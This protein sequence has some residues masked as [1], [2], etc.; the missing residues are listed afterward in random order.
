MRGAV[1]VRSRAALVWAGLALVGLSGCTSNNAASS[2]VTVSGSTLT[3]FASQPPAGSGGQTAAD[4]LHA[5]QLALQQAGGHVG[6]F[7]VKLVPLDGRELSDNARTAIQNQSAIAYLGE[8]QPGTSQ[9]S[10]QITNQQGVL[11]VSPADT[12]AYLTQPTPV[13][14]GAPSEYYPAHSTYHETFAR[15]VP[16]SGAEAKAQ[17]QEM[18]SLGVSK[19]YVAH[20]AQA[21]SAAIALEVTQEAKAA[22]LTAATSAASADGVFYA[23]SSDSPSARASATTAL[24]Q[25][26]S[27]NPT[28]KLFAPSGLYNPSLVSGL[29]AAAQKNLYV[30]SPGFLS[31]DLSPSGRQFVSAFNTAYGHDPAPQA[32]FGFEAMDALLAVLGQAGSSANNRAAVVADFRGLKNR[33]SVLGTYSISGGDPTIAPFIFARAQGGQLKPFKFLSG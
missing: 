26:A 13:V 20:D 6:K 28:A 8:L 27:A 5:E 4:V 1:L 21:Y 12:A 11:E 33:Q 7:K 29:S 3:V 18:R 24:D 9:I 32:I 10:V 30:S 15:V 16:N 17:V 19:L 23:G 14:P 22:G 2:V 31:S 25:A